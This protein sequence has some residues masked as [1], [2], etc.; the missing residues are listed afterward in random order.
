M[1]HLKDN[2]YNTLLPEGII[3]SKII[4]L[5][6]K[7]IEDIDEL[8]NLTDKELINRIIDKILSREDLYEVKKNNL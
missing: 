4:R 2:I 7:D 3:V 1:Y 5:E 6:E 8:I